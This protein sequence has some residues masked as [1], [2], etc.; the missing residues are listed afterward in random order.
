MRRLPIKGLM[1][2][3]LV[4]ALSAA[5]VQARPYRQVDAGYSAPG[6]LWLYGADA[7][8]GVFYGCA[9]GNGCVTFPI[10][11]GA[12]SVE[13]EIADQSGFPTLGIVSGVEDSE[14]SFVCG[15]SGGPLTLLEEI[16][17]EPLTEITVVLATGTC[18]DGTPSVATS[19]EVTATFS[20]G[21]TS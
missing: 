13:I 2:T 11:A 20:G 19:G 4:L 9:N 1:A 10:P 12:T 15:T 3:A 5:P 7:G 16:D 6:A 17:G 18:L 8:A 21:K 14:A